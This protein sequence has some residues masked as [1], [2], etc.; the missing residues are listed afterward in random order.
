MLYS[1]QVPALR[2]TADEEL[3]KLIGKPHPKIGFIPS[4]SDTTR[5][6]FNDR[7]VFYRELGMDLSVYFELDNEWR[8]GKLSTLLKCD[9]I[10]LSGGNTFYFLSWLRKRKMMDIL[11]KYVVGG[12][13]LVGVSAGAILMTPDISTAAFPGD[14]QMPGETDTTGLGLVD[15]AFIPHYGNRPFTIDNV[16]K[17]AREKRT[18]VY[19][20]RDTG[21]ITVDNSAVNC[22]GDVFIVD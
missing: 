4:S 18:T 1:D 11:V 5:K 12:G 20:A 8:P 15:F 3:K 10:H 21:A 13:V 22:I 6:Y 16:K 17:Y 9:A 14:S 7:R 2:K 19:L